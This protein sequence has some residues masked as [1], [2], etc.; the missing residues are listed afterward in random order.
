MYI[1]YVVQSLY[2]LFDTRAMPPFYFVLGPTSAAV[3]LTERPPLATAA[4]HHIQLQPCQTMSYTFTATRG[5]D[6]SPVF[7]VTPDIE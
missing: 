4:V 5:A 6:G 7:N 3:S 2:V 1:Y